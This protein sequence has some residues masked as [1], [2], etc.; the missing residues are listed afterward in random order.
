[1]LTALPDWTSGQVHSSEGRLLQARSFRSHTLSRRRKR[2]FDPAHTAQVGPQPQENPSSAFF[3]RPLPERRLWFAHLTLS[4]V[5]AWSQ[6]PITLRW[7]MGSKI[8][9]C[10]ATLASRR[11]TTESRFPS[12]RT[13]THTHTIDQSCC[14]IL[15]CFMF[16]RACLPAAAGV[17]ACS[18]PSAT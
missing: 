4:L 1:M 17:G 14:F 15:S 2:S 11:L 10:T 13:G 7:H 6:S 16:S 18:Y 3:I 8:G 9:T 5:F 12:P